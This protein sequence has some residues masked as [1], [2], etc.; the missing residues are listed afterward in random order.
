METDLDT[1][2]FSVLI[3]EVRLAAE[4]RTPEAT[5]SGDLDE[6]T[7]IIGSWL[8]REAH[9]ALR[10]AHEMMTD[11]IPSDTAFFLAVDD[12]GFQLAHAYVQSVV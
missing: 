11:G 3:D 2:P 10:R 12:M 5:L 1:S 7:T 6:M 9:L 4:R 8:G